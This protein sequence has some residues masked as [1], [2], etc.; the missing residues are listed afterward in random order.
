ML[1]LEYIRAAH[2]GTVESPPLSEII[3]GLLKFSNNV[4]AELIGATTTR[5]LAGRPLAQ[6]ES[7]AALAAWLKDHF[8]A[9]EWRGFTLVN[10]SGLGTGN[11]ASLI[12]RRKP[13]RRRECVDNSARPASTAI[14][15]W[16]SEIRCCVAS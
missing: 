6:A 15:L 7:G 5:K 2:D 11:R 3:K 10:H 9:T 1:V 13:S 12:A 14:R 16:P 8:P 4:T